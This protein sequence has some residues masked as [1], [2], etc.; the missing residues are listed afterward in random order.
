[1]SLFDLNDVTHHYGT[2]CALRNVSFAAQPGAI[3]LV[4]QNGA[5]KSTLLQILLGI[6]RPS[7]GSARVLGLDVSRAGLQLRGRVGYMPERDALV[8][9]LKGIEYVALAGRLCG[10]PHRQA[11]RRSH[12]VLS[13]LHLEEARYRPLEQYSVGMKQRLKL[14]A[15][16]VHDPD[17]LLLD[18]P[19]AGLDPEGRLAMLQVLRALASRP[20]RSLVLSSHLLGDVE[21]VCHSAII[22]SG[23][24]IVRAG[25]IDQLRQAH[26]GSYRIQWQGD[27]TAMLDALHR[28]GVR[29]DV[30]E[31]RDA[32]RI[33]LPAG[34]ATRDVFA[35]AVAQ[36]VVLTGLEPDEEDFEMV[37]QRL[38]RGGESVREGDTKRP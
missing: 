32:A 23:G 24:R 21:R 11:H 3:G 13:Y 15:T 7:S 12:E 25:R 8:P 16:L 19:T 22:L 17:V 2:V 38:V 26:R 36:N 5:G 29:M 33:L 14:A 30:G 4:G 37:Y 18:E 28:R 31:H 34:L 1:M 9:G 27:A 35:E 20:G 6:L 10:M